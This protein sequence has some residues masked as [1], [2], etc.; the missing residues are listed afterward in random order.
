[1]WLY[2]IE[3]VRVSR[4]EEVSQPLLYRFD[5]LWPHRVHQEI[6][7]WHDVS[8]VT[9]ERGNFILLK[10]VMILSTSD[11]IPGIELI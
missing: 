5:Y 11:T 3:Y 4:V 8:F 1:M 10:Y 7:T 9:E 6:I 2:L